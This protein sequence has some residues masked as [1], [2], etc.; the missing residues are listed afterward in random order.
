VEDSEVPL[1]AP[2]TWPLSR[3]LLKTLAELEP[4]DPRHHLDRAELALASRDIMDAEQALQ[5][6]QAATAL[7]ARSLASGTGLLWLGVAR[8]HLEAG[9]LDRA[10]TAV[11]CALVVSPALAEAEELLAELERPSPDRR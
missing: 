6:A 8:G 11:Q 10:K 3:S 7:G 9:R 1:V 5:S 4:T 2:R